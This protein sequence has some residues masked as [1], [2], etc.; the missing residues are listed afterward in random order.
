MAQQLFERIISLLD[1]E[2]IFYKHFHHEPTVTSEESADIRGT[3]PEQGAKALIF[4]AD[5][6]YIQAIVPSHLRLGSKLFKKLY[7]IHDLELATEEEVFEISGCKK[8]AVP[9][10]GNLF[11]LA[12]YVDERL[13][14]NDE[15]AFNAGLRT[16]SIVMKYEDWEKLV[17]PE[18]GLFAK[19]K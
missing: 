14:E 12:V 17:K 2:N 7:N 10:F 5:G 8:G 16:D 4:K 1:E 9:P 13:S 18:K 6:K 3:T 19:K 11:G 15:I